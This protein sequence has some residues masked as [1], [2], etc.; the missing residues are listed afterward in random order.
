M[1]VGEKGWRNRR[2]ITTNPNI[3]LLFNA[4]ACLCKA[5]QSDK[6]LDKEIWAFIVYEL[7]KE[8]ENK[9]TVSFFI[10]NK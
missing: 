6:A 2:D 5:L 8:T 4:Y 7:E 9:E 1:S 10:N 3:Q